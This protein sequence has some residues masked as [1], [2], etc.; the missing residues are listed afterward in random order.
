M[1]F[2]KISLTLIIL[3]LG[4]SFAYARKKEPRYQQAHQL[5]ADQEALVQK[6]IGQE[7]V[8]I[9][10]IQEHTPLV[11]TY[12]QDTRPDVKLYEVPVD[13]QY[14]LSRVDFSKAFYDKAYEPRSRDKKGFFKNSLAS[15]TGLTKALG[16]DKHFTYNP[17]GF[18]QM[19]FLDPSGFDQQHY[20]F[21]YVRR[22]F[23]GQ[24]RTWVFDVHP[25]VSG[26][27]RFYGRIWIE[28]QDGNVVR[29]NGTYTGP[30]NEDD[31]RHYF[32]FDSWRMNV[33][34][35]VWLPVA[36]YVEET[37]RGDD[38]KS[39]GLKA[40][41]HFWGYSLK[42][43]TRD[44]E[45]VSMKIEDAEDKSDDSQD[46]SPLQASREW[47]T[48]AENNVIDRLEEAGLVAPL[49]Q[50]GYEQQVLDQ[51]LVNL[52]VPNNL[53]FS[54]PVRCRVMLT[55]TVEA[56]TV[57]NTILISKG[58]ID[59]LPNEE[60][61]A[62]V[63][64]LELAHIVL[65]HH[66]DTRYAF[67]DRLLFPDESTFK[68]IDMNHSDTDNAAAAK[69]AMEFLSASMYKDKFA[70]AGL[71]WEQLADRGKELKA[72]NTP[73]LGDSMLKPDGTPWMAELAH[74][75]PKINWD[76][77]TQIPALPLGSWLKTDPWDDKVKMLNAKRYAPM[78]A[79]DKMPLEVTPVYFKLQRYEDANAAPATPAPGAAAPAAQ[80][81]GDQPAAAPPAN[82]A[83]QQQP[84]QQPAPSTP[85][86]Q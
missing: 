64:A 5:T 30:T 82:G 41:T 10:A 80:P 85:N 38:N 55:D 20:V 68:R 4:V 12:I 69:K 78:N 60:A 44:S 56:T 46:V 31:S 7:K 26:M 71:Y 2:R 76:D 42:L 17:T 86:P 49:T 54:S 67:N 8:L 48:Q 3:M 29:F 51:I 52:A 53:A 37:H 22:E 47:V 72:L 21:S 63:V 25:K 19:M 61:I 84:A 79:R 65:G 70:T 34:P 39:L 45:N 75:A 27:G 50:N 24:V 36:I 23:L 33:Q 77:L 59:T 43:P 18:M 32:H 15:I 6:A 83:D 57:G 28:D 40:Q 66:I 81:A 35:G 1:T 16:L 58:L 74:D 62:S 11:E 14:M 73:L 13:D 9:K